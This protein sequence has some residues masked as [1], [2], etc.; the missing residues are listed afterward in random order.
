MSSTELIIVGVELSPS[1]YSLDIAIVSQKPGLVSGVWNF[2]KPYTNCVWTLLLVSI[3]TVALAYY[4]IL[5]A[6]EYPRANTGLLDIFFLKLKILCG[7]S[8]RTVKQ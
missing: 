8:N 4:S 5:K 6:S 3:V 2:T 1:V 7:Q